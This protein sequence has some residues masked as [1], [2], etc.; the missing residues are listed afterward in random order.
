VGEVE[1][2]GP[3]GVVELQRLGDRVEYEA[4]TPAMAP[5]SSLE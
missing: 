1:Q 4:D 2:V 5:R 3:F